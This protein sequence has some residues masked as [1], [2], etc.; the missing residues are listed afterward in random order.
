MAR[1]GTRT[2][3][4]RPPVAILDGDP[5]VLPDHGAEAMGHR[6][7]GAAPGRLDC[8]RG[9]SPAGGQGAAVGGLAARALRRRLRAG[10]HRRRR[11]SSGRDAHRACRWRSPGATSR[12]RLGAEGARRTPLSVRPAAGGRL[13]LRRTG[14]SRPAPRRLELRRPGVGGASAR[15]AGGGGPRSGHGGRGP[16]PAGTGGGASDGVALGGLGVRPHVGGRR[17]T[18]RRSPRGRSPGARRRRAGAS[19]PPGCGRL[20]LGQPPAPSP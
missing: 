11:A 19:A 10:R 14:A 1:R 8:A 5:R 9:W 13:E 4:A 6:A 18:G 7:A 15:S 2:G 12:C 17:G 16:A 3:T 20:S